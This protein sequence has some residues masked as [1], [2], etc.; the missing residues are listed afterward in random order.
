MASAKKGDLVFVHYSGKFDSGDVFDSSVDADPIYFVLGE[1]NL[2]AGF[3]TAINGMKVG[4]KKSITIAPENGYGEYS[5]EKIIKTNRE[6]FGEDFEPQKNL[7]LAL[8]LE[9][10]HQTLATVTDFDDSMVTLDLN[11]P[12]A[13]K[14]LHFDLELVDIKDASQLPACSTDSCSSCQSRSGCGD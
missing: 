7:Q 3:E 13:G 8:Q 12:L 9:G 11:H 10:G 6:N 5:D 1:G 4:D 2:I 14:T